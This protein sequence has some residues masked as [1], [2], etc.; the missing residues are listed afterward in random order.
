M[1]VLHALFFVIQRQRIQR[2][3]PDFT[4]FYTGGMVLRQGIGSQLYDPHTQYQVQQQFA[5]EINSRQGPLP[6]IHPPFEALFF[7]PLTLLP[8]HVAFV[9]WDV[10]NVIALFGVAL[11]LRQNLD[12]LHAVPPWEFVLGF[13]AFFPVFATLLQGQDSILLLLLCAL[14]FNALKRNSDFLAG[15]WFALGTFKFQ[16]VIPLVLLLVFWKR[17]RVGQLRSR[18]FQLR[19]WDGASFG[20]IRIT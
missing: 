12:G 18:L 5:G 13:L 1:L 6:Y 7:L 15:G 16:L 4:V 8:Y 20:N 9:T 10:L 14:G 3:Y 19:W 11:L 2:G 17:K